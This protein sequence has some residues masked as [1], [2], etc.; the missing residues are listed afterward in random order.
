MVAQAFDPSTRETE[1]SVSL[2]PA[3]STELVPG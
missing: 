2:R 1:V 3:C